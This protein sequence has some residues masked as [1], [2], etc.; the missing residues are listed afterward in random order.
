MSWSWSYAWSCLPN[1][2]RGMLITA[3]V[4][5]LGSVIALVAGLFWAILV[6]SGV[7]GVAHLARLIV[8]FVRGTPLVVQ[9]F[10]FYYALPSIG[11]SGGP[12]VI[13]VFSLGLYGSAYMAEVY[14]AGIVNLPRGQWE[15]AKVL[16]LPPVWQ[17]IDVVIPQVFRAVLPALGNNIVVMLKYTPV[18]STITVTELLTAGLDLGAESYRYLEPLTLAGVAFIVITIPCVLA[19]RVLERRLA[20][21]AA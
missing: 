1:L 21:G 6:L 17:W 13:G 3:E 19:L 8:D 11:I 12:F 14:R 5:A 7:P 9:V 2:L 15:A 20:R 10:F 4:T 16:R 18:L